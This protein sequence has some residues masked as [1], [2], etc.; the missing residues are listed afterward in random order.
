M[1]LGQGLKDIYHA[2]SLVLDVRERAAAVLRTVG[3]IVLRS[4]TIVLRRSIIRTGVAA[5]H[6]LPGRAADIAVAATATS[7]DSSS[8]DAAE[9]SLHGS[10]ANSQPRP[11][12]QSAG[13]ITCH[14]NDRRSDDASDGHGQARLRDV[15]RRQARDLASPRDWRRTRDAY[16]KAKNDGAPA[17]R[18]PD[19]VESAAN[20]ERAYTEWLA[21][22]ARSTSSS[23][24]PAIFAWPIDLRGVPRRRSAATSAPA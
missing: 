14:T 24:I 16:E 22:I 4:R 9:R 8:G 6:D 10:R 3:P 20:P 15:P 23:S 12:P 18:V 17:P 11:R 7:S 5:L 2:P 21:G 13:C 19:L 1:T